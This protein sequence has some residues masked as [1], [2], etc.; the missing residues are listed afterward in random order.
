MEDATLEATHLYIAS[1]PQE[2][3][4]RQCWCGSLKSNILTGEKEIAE[5]IYKVVMAETPSEVLFPG[6]LAR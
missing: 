6:A 3:M 4:I 5:P 1:L 2:V